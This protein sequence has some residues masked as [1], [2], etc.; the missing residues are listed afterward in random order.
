MFWK[1]TIFSSVERKDW[2]V[3]TELVSVSF[4]EEEAQVVV[5]VVAILWR[6][7]R[8]PLNVVIWSSLETLVMV[9]LI[10]DSVTV[11]E[12]AVSLGTEIEL[13]SV[14]DTVALDGGAVDWHTVGFSVEAE[15]CIVLLTEAIA[16]AESALGRVA[17]FTSLLGAT[18]FADCVAC[19]E[20]VELQGDSLD[21]WKIYR[22]RLKN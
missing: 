19:I 13:V 21:C 10:V 9:L 16:R 12:T 20:L 4:F 15:V 7:L 14:L 17:V 5:V 18:T 6:H 1:F 22:E 2:C 8:L 11:L 3:M